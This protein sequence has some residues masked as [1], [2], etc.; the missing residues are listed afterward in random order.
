M[1]RKIRNQKTKAELFVEWIEKKNL[2]ACF[3]E[4]RN[5]FPDHFL[6]VEPWGDVTVYFGDS[7]SVTIKDNKTEA[8]QPG[9]F[10]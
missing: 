2:K 6:E 8:N 10:S 9:V 7:S 3:G 5:E 4:I 1:A